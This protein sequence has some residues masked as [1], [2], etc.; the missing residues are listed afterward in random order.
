[1]TLVRVGPVHFQPLEQEL[2]PVAKYFAGH[3]L[4]AGCGTRD[5]ARRF[6]RHHCIRTLESQPLLRGRC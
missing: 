3:V 6:S 4:N 1:M 2:E 5:E